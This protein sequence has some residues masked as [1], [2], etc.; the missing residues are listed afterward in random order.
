[1][2]A[3]A[4]F[5]AEWQA[6]L[7]PSHI[8]IER[9]EDY[10]DHPMRVLRRAIAHLGLRAMKPAELQAARAARAV[11]T[12]EKVCK[13]HGLPPAPALAAVRAF[14]APFNRAL[15]RQLGDTSFLWHDSAPSL[16][17]AD[18]SAGDV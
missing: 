12:L 9:T 3:D 2:A 10:V 15:A 4:V 1:M 7:P 18:A 14:Y 5:L 8:L 17:A 6:A 13:G 11:D 16:I